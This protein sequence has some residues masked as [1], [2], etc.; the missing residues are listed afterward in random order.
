MGTVQAV[1]QLFTDADYTFD[2]DTGIFSAPKVKTTGDIYTV[3]WSDYASQSTIVGFDSFTNKIIR[4]KQVGNLVFCQYVLKGAG[5]SGVTSMSFTLPYY[6]I[7]LGSVPLGPSVN[8]DN[9]NTYAGTVH[10]GGSNIFYIYRQF[11]DG[12]F[13]GGTGTVE[14]RGS[15]F[16]EPYFSA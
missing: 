4:Y 2:P 15:F 14:L 11:I 12:E 7:M 13:S 5:T 9:G 1:S 3:A 8:I 6:D 10:G 16:F